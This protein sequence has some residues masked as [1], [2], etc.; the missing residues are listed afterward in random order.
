MKPL[1]RVKK[2][3][4]C[5]IT[6]PHFYHP[7]PQK[8]IIPADINQKISIGMTALPPVSGAASLA[9]FLTSRKI[10]LPFFYLPIQP[11]R[12]FGAVYAW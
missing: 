1:I 8:R 7:N 6:R 11:F 5:F 12:Q 4:R 2:Q 10:I 3:S 9:I